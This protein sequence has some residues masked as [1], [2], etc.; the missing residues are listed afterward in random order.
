M[1]VLTAIP[2]YN[3]ARH[4]EAV[5]HEVSRYNPD[6][7]VVNDGSTDGT[8]EILARHPEVRVISTHATEAMA[9]R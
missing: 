6:V 4:V 9:P 8:A 1:R 5:L 7:L 3:E 2:V